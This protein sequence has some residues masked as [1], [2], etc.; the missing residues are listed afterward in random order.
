MRH[1][2]KATFD[3]LRLSRL[4]GLS[5][6][7]ETSKFFIRLKGISLNDETSKFFIR[8]KGFSSNDESSKFLFVC[9]TFRMLYG[10]NVK[11]FIYL[12]WLLW[13]AP[14]INAQFSMTLAHKSDSIWLM[15]SVISALNTAYAIWHMTPQKK[16]N[17][18]PHFL[19]GQLKR[20]AVVLDPSVVGVRII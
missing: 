20:G 5:S 11:A 19:G 10:L 7:G 13:M 18:K 15:A 16:P 14:I 17:R 6:N 3:V 9:N 12:S 8:L 2:A 4:K 1:T